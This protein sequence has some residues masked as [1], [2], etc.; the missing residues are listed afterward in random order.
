MVRY[1]WGQFHYNQDLFT[2]WYFIY[3]FQITAHGIRPQETPVLMLSLTFDLQAMN[4]T[5]ASR[6]VKGES[7]GLSEIKI[8]G[9]TLSTPCSKTWNK[10]CLKQS[11]FIGFPGASRK[12]EVVSNVSMCLNKITP[13]I[14]IQILQT[15]LH[16]FLSRIVEGIWF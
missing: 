13:K 16:T 12:I 15:D 10:C 2:N 14:H 1:W 4:N 11:T 8:W 3:H 5:K 6:K 7:H 9:F